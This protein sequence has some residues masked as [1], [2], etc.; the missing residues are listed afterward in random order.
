MFSYWKWRHACNACACF[1]TIYLYLY[2][3]YSLHMLLE[4]EMC[5]HW[6]TCLDVLSEPAMRCGKWAEPPD[7]HSNMFFCFDFLLCFD[8]ILRP[9]LVISLSLY[10]VLILSTCFLFSPWLICLLLPSCVFC[11][12]TTACHRHVRFWATFARVSFVFV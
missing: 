12:S 9:C 2:S 7:L 3:L 11:F 5:S 8:L 1:P 6:K 4:W 10:C